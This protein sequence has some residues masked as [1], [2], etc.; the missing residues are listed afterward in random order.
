MAK[1]I[2]N[3]SKLQPDIPL[4]IKVRGGPLNGEEMITD[5]PPED[6]ACFLRHSHFRV[7]GHTYKILSY[8]LVKKEVVLLY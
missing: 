7:E 4:I 3:D 6:E 1:S 2:T 8:D 5:M